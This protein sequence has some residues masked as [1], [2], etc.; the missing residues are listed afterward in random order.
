MDKIN[1]RLSQSLLSND[2]VN[3]SKMTNDVVAKHLGAFGRE[4]S[5][6]H[7]GLNSQV[8]CGSLKSELTKL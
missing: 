7:L 4:S 8:E 2:T 1:E 5:R 3:I 6:Y